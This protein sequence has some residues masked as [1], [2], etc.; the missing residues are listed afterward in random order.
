MLQQRAGQIIGRD[1][2][3][4]QVNCQDALGMGQYGPY[5]VGIV[6]D[7]CSEGANSEVGAKLAAR[8]LVEEAGRLLGQQ[9]P[10]E[11]VPNLLYAGLVRYLNAVLVATQPENRTSFVTDNL[12]FTVVGMIVSEGGGV[13]FTAGDGL[14]LIDND[15][16]QIDQEN[17]P[18][19]PA[20]HLV[21][22][23]LPEDYA[24]PCA[25]DVQPIPMNWQQVAIA[26]DGF[27][28]DLLPEVWCQTHP[29][30]LQRRMNVWSNQEYRFQD[31][32]TIITIE[33]LSAERDT[34]GE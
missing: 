5:A 4:R 24:M 29:R 34:D 13:V 2:L 9:Q 6:C 27:E 21:K 20:Y 32:A 14:T 15:L 33:R 1:H 26:S 25:F 16:R 11:A 30:G 3:A 31:D 23:A 19:Y 12:L 10:P 28:A 18:A 8:Y 7:G 17:R 22:D